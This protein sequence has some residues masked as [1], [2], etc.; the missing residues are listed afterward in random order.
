MSDDIDKIWM[1]G[2]PKEKRYLMMVICDV[3]TELYDRCNPEYIKKKVKVFV[4]AAEKLD[5]ME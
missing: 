1:E 3:A 4:D 5:S 2:L